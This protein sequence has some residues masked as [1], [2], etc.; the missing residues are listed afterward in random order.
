MCLA[1]DEGKYSLWAPL[2]PPPSPSLFTFFEVFSRLCYVL[3]TVYVLG[4]SRSSGAAQRASGGR[5]RVNESRGGAGCSG[6]VCGAKSAPKS[7]GGQ[8]QRNRQFLAAAKFGRAAGRPHAAGTFLTGIKIYAR[9]SFVSVVV[10]VVAYFVYEASACTA[11]V[12]VNGNLYSR[13]SLSLSLC[14]VGN[15]SPVHQSQPLQLRALERV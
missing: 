9:Y 15:A 10:V 4:R 13:L 8:V 14:I 1:V 6:A 11:L 2:K 3:L 12:F 5:S 7:H